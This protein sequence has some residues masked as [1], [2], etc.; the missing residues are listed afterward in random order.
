MTNVVR[1]PKRW[2]K[3]EVKRLG[4]LKEVSGTGT[5]AVQGSNRT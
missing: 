2:T 4:E 1:K 3:P 5:G